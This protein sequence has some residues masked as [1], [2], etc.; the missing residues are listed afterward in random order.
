MTRIEIARKGII[1]DEIKEVSISESVA[2]ESLACDISNGL[3]VVPRNMNRSIKPVG[4]GK[5][6]KTKVNANIGTFLLN[7]AQTRL[8]TFRLVDLSKT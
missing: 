4:I 2:P 3:A 8:W 6:L 5:G 7:T 1:T